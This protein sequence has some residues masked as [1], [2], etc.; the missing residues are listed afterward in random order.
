M[1]VKNKFEM[2][3]FSEICYVGSKTAQPP[4]DFAAFLNVLRSKLGDNSVRAARAPAVMFNSLKVRNLAR[5][6]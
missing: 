1:F 6:Y 2:E 4:T 3:A 5:R